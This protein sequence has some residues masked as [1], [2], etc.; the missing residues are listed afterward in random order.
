[1][2]SSHCRIMTSQDGF[3]VKLLIKKSKR[4]THHKPVTEATVL[5]STLP[6]KTIIIPMTHKIRPHSKSTWVV[7]NITAHLYVPSG[8]LYQ[9]PLLEKASA[10]HSFCSG[11]YWVEVCESGGICLIPPFSQRPAPISWPLLCFLTWGMEFLAVLIVQQPSLSW[12]KRLQKET[13]GNCF[14]HSLHGVHTSEIIFA[15]LKTACNRVPQ[16]TANPGRHQFNSC[17]LISDFHQSS[18]VLLVS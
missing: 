12:S 10:C 18:L 17:F 4:A 5:F 11:P 2:L 16:E 13:G 6:T 9:I 7:P 1:M 15:A 14:L 3:M 8:L